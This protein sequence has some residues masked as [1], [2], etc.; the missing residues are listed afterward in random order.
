M[1]VT[2]RPVG[3]KKP[4]VWEFD[5]ATV[6]LSAADMIER[7]YSADRPSFDQ[8]LAAVQGGS[9]RARRVLLW[10]LQWLEHPKIRLEDVDPPR[11][12]LEVEYTKAEIQDM[13]DSVE[14]KKRMDD[15]E[16]Q[17]ILDALYG[18]LEGAPEGSGKAASPES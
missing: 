3:A 8:W 12:A 10:Y 1:I 7:R 13:I 15:G 5:P 9:A 14:K 17:E 4:W 16:R 2:Y 18:D 11:S 6:P